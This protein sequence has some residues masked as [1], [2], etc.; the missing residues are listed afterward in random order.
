MAEKQ[1]NLSQGVG[2]PAYERY[3]AAQK[4]FEDMLAERENRLFDPTLLAMAQGFLSPT[5]TGSFGESLGNVAGAVAPVQAAEDKRTMD[6][7]RMRLEMAQ[8]GV[9]TDIQRKQ[10]EARQRA[11]NQE[12][13][14]ESPYYRPI[15]SS[16]TAPPVQQPAQ[17]PAGAL[18]SASVGQPPTASVLPTQASQPA[19]Q[20]AP[21]SALPSAPQQAP[22]QAPAPLAQAM[23]AP[24]AP[25][26]PSGT[27]L[28]PAQPYALNPEERKLFAQGLAANKDPYEIRK[29]IME[30]RRKNMVVNPAGTVGVNVATGQKFGF[31]PTPT[32]TY[33]YGYGNYK[34]PATHATM[35]GEAQQDPD[36]YAQ[37][38]KMI[39]FGPQ[40]KPAAPST[41]N[42]T[43]TGA[44][45]A[46]APAQR[47][48]TTQ[49]EAEGAQSKA[50]ATKR[51]EAR[52]GRTN[53]AL[54]AVKAAEDTRI[55]AQSAKDVI[56]QPNSELFMGIFE[57]PKIKTA[58]A[59]MVEDTVFAPTNFREA[60]TSMNIALSVPR[61][62]GENNKDYTE[63]KQEVMD[64]Y[65]EAT[66]LMAQAK[67]AASLLSKG[68]GT[69]TDGE[70]KLFADTTINTKMSVN[71]FNKISDMLIER[72]KFAEDLGSKL[73]LNRM[74][75]DDF[76]QTPEYK[77]MAREYEG[78][79]SSILRSGRPSSSSG[80][81]SSSSSSGG[82]PDLDA[83]QANIERQLR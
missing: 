16:V 22:Q 36:K 48:T 14:E 25:Q 57:K 8:Q 37:L 76:K 20:P 56:N 61:E 75:I 33:I 82:R 10:A 79:L 67:F 41:P 50:E 66:T 1:A 49:S 39:V 71:A 13:G 24:Q 42:A 53:T 55:I 31:D 32:D 51:G 64:R 29:D 34:I 44:A 73:A 52:E 15:A 27:Q 18:P 21:Q 30:T 59:K 35:L 72:S 78:R 12:L 28:F 65:I 43:P 83:A 74:Q 3:E 9:Q 11:I 68:Q 23:Q 69:I 4:R 63:R 81:R 5:K 38:A 19:A 47:P 40:A 45:P 58:L 60:I 54:D 6:M 70:R 2:T 17:Q 7:A 26:E 62:P 77:K 46:G 80:N